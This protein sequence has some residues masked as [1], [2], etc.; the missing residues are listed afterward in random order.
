MAPTEKKKE[1]ELDG[2]WD[3]CST[4][5]AFTKEEEKVAKPNKQQA[6]IKE[7]KKHGPSLQANPSPSKKKK[8]KTLACTE[9]NDLESCYRRKVSIEKAK[10]LS[11]AQ[12][13]INEAQVIPKTI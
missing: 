6:K 3:I 1:N 2:Y 8:K 13:E 7:V 5:C 11:K 9:K 10:S 4:L 12:G